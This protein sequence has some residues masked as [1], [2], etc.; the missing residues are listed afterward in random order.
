MK[1]KCYRC[2]EIFKSDKP[3][4]KVTCPQ[5]KATFDYTTSDDAI[6][7]IPTKKEISEFKQNL[8]NSLKFLSSERYEFYPRKRD[9]LQT[10]KDSFFCWADEYNAGYFSE[11]EE[12]D[13]RYCAWLTQQFRMWKRGE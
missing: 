10:L 4:E 6:L 7:I 8:Y 1:Y 13:D 9:S 11:M 12:K 2:L 3:L 5:C